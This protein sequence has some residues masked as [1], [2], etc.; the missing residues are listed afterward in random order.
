MILLQV[1]PQM[2]A[3]NYGSQFHTHFGYL[4]YSPVGENT[5]EL[6]APELFAR[7][8]IRSTRWFG[9]KQDLKFL[10]CSGSHPQ[11]IM[12]P[13]IQIQTNVNCQSRSE[14]TVILVSKNC[15]YVKRS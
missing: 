6:Y 14:A 12:Q 11:L 1:R 3:G 13:H 10:P 7:V 2:D 5:A 9:A 4:K 15:V 8:S